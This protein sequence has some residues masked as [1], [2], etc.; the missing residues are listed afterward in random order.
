MVACEGDWT[1]DA[2]QLFI[3]FIQ[4]IGTRSFC[5][6]LT[7]WRYV[8]NP[9][10]GVAE[11]ATNDQPCCPPAGAAEV[12]DGDQGT[13]DDPPRSTAPAADEH[14]AFSPVQAF[15]LRFACE[16]MAALLV[17]KEECLRFAELWCGLLVSI[18][19]GNYSMQ[20]AT[21]LHP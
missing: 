20:P 12:A 8:A 4:C 18:L 13:T 1:F 17:F 2:W 11:V 6:Q 14:H 15:K 5:S 10:A 16:D 21:C 9:V 3:L 19:D 7:V